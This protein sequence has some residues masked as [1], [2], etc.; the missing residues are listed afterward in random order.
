[1]KRSPLPT[2][3]TTGPRRPLPPGQPINFR[4]CRVS[5]L[6]TLPIR[7][8]PRLQ[9]LDFCL[10][11]APGMTGTGRP[12][13]LGYGSARHAGGYVL[14]VFLTRDASDWFLE[15]ET[16]CFDEEAGRRE[17]IVWNDLL[18]ADLYRAIQR[19][20]LAAEA[21]AYGRGAGRN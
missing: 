13:T 18:L 2:I 7:H 17:S 9:V 11:N 19:R 16:R 4:R 8:N 1:M 3:G 14:R 15:T 20:Q 21:Q 5:D 12:R 10:T 6:R